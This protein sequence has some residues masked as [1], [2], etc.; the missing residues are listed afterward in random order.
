MGPPSVSGRVYPRPS[1]STVSTELWIPRRLTRL[2][3]A[4]IV[5]RMDPEP[6]PEVAPLA[7]LLGTWRGGG[8]GVY[9]TIRS[10]RY[11]EELRFWHLGKPFLAYQQ[12][13]WA[14]DDGRQLA[15]E[16]GYW[17]MT[18]VGTVEVVLAHPT[19]IVEVLEG[20]LDGG[21]VELAT[22]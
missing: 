11:T 10:F 22:T 5:A 3:G 13:S 8:D 9:P 21:R 15:S 19:G 2:W 18:A 6:H 7:W 20:R 14:A 4:G 16:S 1:R 17:R 12:R